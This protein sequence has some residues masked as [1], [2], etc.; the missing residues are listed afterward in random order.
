MAAGPSTAH[1]LEEM[2]TA[3]DPSALRHPVAQQAVLA[4]AQALRQRLR[5]SAWPTPYQIV[6]VAYCALARDRVLIADDQGVGK[7]QPVDT[8]VLT[9]TGWCQIG[10]IRVGDHVIGSAGQAVLV[11]GVFPQGVQPSF[12]VRLNDGA[13]VEAG[14]DHLWTVFHYRGGR[15]YAPLQLTTRD[16]YERPVIAGAR[17]GRTLD[18]ARTHL[19]LPLLSAPA[20]FAEQPPLPIDP[21]LLGHLIANGCLHLDTPKL[22][23]GDHN[24]P[25]VKSVLVERGVSVDHERTYGHC[26]HANFRG[27]T[28]IIRALN[29]DK[30]SGEK[31]VPRD[32]MTASV[33]DRTALFRGLMD[34]DGTASTERN[35]IA[36]CSTNRALAEDVRELVEG[37]G[38]IATVH[39]C[40]RSH[41]QKPTDYSVSMRLPPWLT[42]F[43]VESRASCYNPGSRSHPGRRVEAVEYVRD[44]ES[45]CIQVDAPDHL[46]VTE[47]CILT[48]NSA[49]ALCRILLGNHYPAVVIAP[50]TAARAVWH[51]VQI[52]M[53]LPGALVRLVDSTTCWVPP[54]GWRG[55]V[56]TTWDLLRHHS[57]GLAALKPRIVVAD[58]VHKA[59]NEDAQRTQHLRHVLQA[60]P[61]VLAMTG[62]PIRNRGQDLWELMNLIAPDAWPEDALPLFKEL[63]RDDF[64]RGVQTRLTRRLSQ[65]ML[66]R[67]K[68]E[69]LPDL[70]AK[71]INPVRVRLP[72]PVMEEYRR[73]ERAFATWLEEVTREKVL[74]ERPDLDA[75]QTEEEIDRRLETTLRA[76]GLAKFGHLCRFVGMAKVPMALKWIRD[77]TRA[78]E[79]VVVFTRHQ[80]PLHAIAAGLKRMKVTYAVVDGS[81]PPKKRAEAVRNFQAGR[82]QVFLA[83][84][85]AQESIT[86][87]KA[88]HVLFV[89]LWLTG[90][91]EDQGADRI[92]RLGQTRDCFVWQLVAVGTVDERVNVLVSRKRRI[93]G[94]TVDARTA[95]PATRSTATPAAPAR[96]RG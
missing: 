91:D 95:K 39:A 14:P 37:M 61:H 31:R 66:R 1:P 90:A 49:L 26:V 78:R 57:V 33:A 45:V 83:S 51:D 11:T 21:Y 96:S 30:P 34:G 40:D 77:A 71:Q 22:V 25:C 10:D 85:A 28:K 58:E 43:R 3:V 59:I 82:L 23:T 87:T 63:N 52:P 53:W 80:D 94:R 38:G 19:Y 44:A 4:A 89:D 88:R 55:I 67:K 56:V 42:P 12:L 48:H 18:L 92:H 74:T 69:A 9:P 73:A 65:F 15:E 35:R 13:S 29:L 72:A 75:E 5:G 84:Q 7:Q 6:G 86:L 8:N 64:D 2:S 62:T 16:L 60:T 70:K 68:E 81:T 17:T 24:W 50:A 32:Y 36:Y 27:I 54:A 46:Y 76:E 93:A 79:P 41:H 20:K 47:H